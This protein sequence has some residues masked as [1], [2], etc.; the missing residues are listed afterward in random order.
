MAVAGLNTTLTD[1]ASPSSAGDYRPV[2][3]RAVAWSVAGVVLVECLYA[4]WTASRGYFWQDDFI[5][6]QALRQLGFDG[7]LFEQPVFGHFIPGFNFVDYLISLIVPYPW[8]LIVL[9]EVLLFG[10]SLFLLDHLLTILFGPSWLGVA[11]VAIAGAS[12]SLVPSLVWWATA[13]EYL[14]AIPATLLACI[15]HV[16]YLRTGRVRYAAFGGGALAI[17]FAFYDGLFVSV[18]FIVLMTVLIWPVAPGLQGVK[19]TLVVHSR[20]W[21]CYGIPVALELGWR[22]SHPGRYITGGSASIA[23]VLGFIGLAWTQTFIPLT[24]GVDAWVLPAHAERIV[25]GLLGQAILVAFV[26][27]TLLRRRSAWRA[28]VLIGATFLF[29]AAIVGATRAGT[30]GPGDASDVKYFALDAFFLVIAVGFALLPVRLST[31]RPPTT[32]AQAESA[33]NR[34]RS[35]LPTARPAWFRAF[36]V[37]TAL[38]VV[39]VYGA[40]LVF[41]QNRDSE[42]TGS[43]ASHR[44]FANFATSW[45]AGTST[46]IHPFLWDTE[47]NP[48]VVTR[49]F[50]PYD[51]ASVTVGRLHPGMRFDE[52]GGTGF[53]LRSDGSVERAT[54]VT[55]ARGLIPG[56]RAC[57]HPPHGPGRIVVALDHRLNGARRWFGAVSYQSAAGAT[58]TQ[59]DGTT[60]VV[61]KGTGT[62][63]TTFPATPLGSIVWS[64]Q[65]R[66][67]VCITALTVV[68]PEPLGTHVRPA[69]RS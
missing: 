42:S 12:F 2:R 41:D 16:R 6:L 47:V 35:H 62:L 58:A 15:F 1:P 66:T 67:S 28:W 11:L 18:L 20:A 60:V 24:F 36:V 52:W 22:F 54:A 57:A 9:L 5:D 63:I 3:S 65:P 55:Q 59:L 31:T 19:Q 14:V 10:L 8:W 53:M 46:A 64:L 48:N 40:V 69:S 30:Y 61:P 39:V 49:T 34:S 21:V 13:L 17:G 38:A 51:T 43:H 68:L 29:G 7:R 23:Q 50:F 32:T 33:S 27:G 26:V 4:L 56:R 45:A 25:A 44:Y 37:V